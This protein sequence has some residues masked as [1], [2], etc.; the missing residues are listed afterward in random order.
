MGRKLTEQERQFYE[1]RHHEMLEKAATGMGL[2]P[3]KLL[4]IERESREKL[5]GE[6][7]RDTLSLTDTEE[8]FQSFIDNLCAKLNEEFSR[9]ELRKLAEKRKA[10]WHGDSILSLREEI[11]LTFNSLLKAEQYYNNR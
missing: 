4:E 5:V 6:A 2:T 3:E 9:R 11:E 1:K 10:S 8:K 7:D